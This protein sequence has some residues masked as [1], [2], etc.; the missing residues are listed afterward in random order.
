M[1]ERP[2]L[3][4]RAATR[5]DAR[6]LARLR[7]ASL[8]ELDLS[9]AGDP[10]FERDATRAFESLLTTHDLIAW[11]LVVDACV[12]GSACALFW[13]RLPYPGS[14]LHAELAGV[15]VAPAYRRRGIARELCREVIAASR[16]RGARRI[17]VH[18]SDA[19]LD[20]YAELGFVGGNELRL[21]TS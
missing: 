18:P 16:A 4:L 19:G 15:Y 9:G 21:A 17:V 7:L 8:R 12:V 1:T 6:A 2:D 14:S 10:T 5:A 3:Y 11:V 20:L 13:Q